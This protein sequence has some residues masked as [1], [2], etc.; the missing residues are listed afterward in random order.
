MGGC[1]LQ[2][3]RT[4]FNLYVLVFDDGHRA[5]YHRHDNLLALEPLVL[6]VIGVDAH[7]HVAHDCFGACGSHDG[8]VS[9][10][11]AVDDIAFLCGNIHTFLFGQVILHVVE[12]RMLLLIDYLFVREGGEGLGVPVYHAYAAIDE[13]LAVEVAED[14]DD[15]LTSLL[16]HGEGRAVP[17]TGAAQC[18]E[19]F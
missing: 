18:P 5:V 14:F 3:A 12:L 8:I 11:V 15:A 13:S 2:T 17:V 6:G 4:E 7:R 1:Y 19:L 10:L 9:T 16:V